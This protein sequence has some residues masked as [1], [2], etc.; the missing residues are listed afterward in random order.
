MRTKISFKQYNPSKP[1]KY[2]L[3]IKSTN[4]TAYS[5]TFTASPYCGRPKEE[6]TERYVSGTVAIVKYLIT[7]FQMHV[8]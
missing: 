8:D 2:G 1:A 4:A 3:L 5:Y 7:K 6:P